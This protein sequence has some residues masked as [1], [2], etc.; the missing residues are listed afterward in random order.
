[1]F[2]S[3][4]NF[5]SRQLYYN[6]NILHYASVLIYMR[7]FFRCF[8]IVTQC[9]LNIAALIAQRCALCEIS[10]GITYGNAETTT[11]KAIKDSHSSRK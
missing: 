10:I 11:P 1:M 2:T 7:L 3:D 9:C 8:L 4:Y 6:M 5:L